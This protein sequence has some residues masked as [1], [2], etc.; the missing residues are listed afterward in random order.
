M[1]NSVSP[2]S[3]ASARAG[4]A[5]VCQPQAGGRFT[6]GNALTGNQ[7]ARLSPRPASSGGAPG[8]ATRTGCPRS[9]T[10]RAAVA[11]AFRNFVSKCR[12]SV[13][14]GGVGKSVHGGFDFDG[15]ALGGD[16]G[17]RV[18]LRESTLTEVADSAKYPLRVRPVFSG[19]QPNVLEP[20]ER[21]AL[22]FSHDPVRVTGRCRFEAEA[23]QALVKKLVDAVLLNVRSRRRLALQQ[24]E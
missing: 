11:L 3:H 24:R 23:R 17:T 22:S 4:S 1:K 13:I 20:P 18:V 16:S 14:C 21:A 8:G 6:S 9:S 10:S 7:P 19:G 15:R 5:R 12:S 2:S